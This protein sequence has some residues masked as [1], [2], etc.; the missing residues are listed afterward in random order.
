MVSLGNGRRLDVSA[1][2]LM[3]LIITPAPGITPTPTVAPTITPSPVPTVTPSDFVPTATPT[4]TPSMLPSQIPATG[5][6]TISVMPWWAQSE[7]HEVV[8]KGF[9]LGILLVVIL[10]ILIFRKVVLDH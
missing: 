2:R 10:T 3:P 8:L 9:H 5:T 6:A 4:I 7:W 1:L